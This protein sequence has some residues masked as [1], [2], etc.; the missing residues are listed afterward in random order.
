MTLRRGLVAG[1]VLGWAVISGSSGL[2]SAAT[3]V[4]GN[5][6]GGFKGQLGDSSYT[7]IAE[8]KWDR[9]RHGDRQRNRSDR[10]R[11]FHGGYYYATPWWEVGVPTP[12]PG[13]VIGVPTPWTPGWF[14]YCERKYGRWKFDRK[15]GRYYRGGR[16]VVCS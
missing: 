2:A 11:Y 12:V 13:I 9:R 10:Y 1:A 16:W 14:S 8:G 6:I 15:T 7:Q 4:A 3:I 5:A